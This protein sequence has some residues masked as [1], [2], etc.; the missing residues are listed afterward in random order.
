MTGDIIAMYIQ[1]GVT[2][3]AG[4]IAWF[5]YEKQKRDAKELAARTILSEIQGGEDAVAKV[6]D[7]IQKDHL[8]ID[9]SVLPSESWSKYKHMFVKDFDKDEWTLISDF[10]NKAPLI[11]EAISFNKTAFAGDVDQ[12]R[13]NRQRLLAT[14]A[15]EAVKQAMFP[16]EP[17]LSTE[18]IKDIYNKKYE[19]FDILYMDKQAETQYKP[20]K[21]VND[22]KMYLADFP[23]LTTSAA[24]IRLKKLAGLK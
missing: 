17:A 6:R 2:L 16:S 4:G 13:S 12:I 8:D 19:A 15:E 21:P 7:A 22:V 10:Y 20:V 18:E 14:Y 11:D 5:I 24:G 9:V 1:S 23:R 3:I